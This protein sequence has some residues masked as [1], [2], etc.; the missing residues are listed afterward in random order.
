M[1][2]DCVFGIDPSLSSTGLVVLDRAGEVLL[3]QA[4]TLGPKGPTGAERLCRLKAMFDGVLHAMRRPAESLLGGRHPL[5]VL[6]GYGY[7]ASGQRLAELGEWVGCIKL[8]LWEAGVPVVIV[9]PA[10]LKRFTCGRGNAQKDE[11]RLAVFKRWGFEHQTNDVVDAYALAQLGRAILGWESRLTRAQEE[12]VR[13]LRAERMLESI[14][15]ERRGR[16][17]GSG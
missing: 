5:V 16:Q 1:T 13:A 12:V 4:L 10:R 11:M 14:P 3:Q 8:S 7:S 15:H 2:A 17:A 6:E 9:P